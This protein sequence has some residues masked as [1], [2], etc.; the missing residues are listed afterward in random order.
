M[1]MLKDL[2][3]AFKLKM[4]LFYKLPGA[5]F[6]GVSVKH[7]TAEKAEVYLPY[8]WRSQNPFKSI[9][10]AAQCAAAEFS[11]GILCLAAINRRPGISMLVTKFSAEFYKKA[12]TRCF[13]TCEQGR[14]VATL[15]EKAI[16]SKEPQVITL[17]STGRNQAGEV[18]SKAWI[19]WS[20]KYR[21]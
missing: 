15:I 17:E 9:Y 3:N 12:N 5:W 14:E 1:V 11:T 8:G 13:F 21:L 18:V 7:I 6:M 2:N 10:F 16:S 4:Y 20:F 19:S